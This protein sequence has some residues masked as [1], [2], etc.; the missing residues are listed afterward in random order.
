MEDQGGERL[1]TQFEFE[2]SIIFITNYD[3][4]GF[5]AKGNRLAPHFEAMISR[6]IYLDLAMKTRRDYMIRIEQIAP[7]MMVEAGMT[8]EDGKLIVDFI[9][10]NCDNLRELSLRMVMK[11]AN[12]MKMNRS[13]W[14]RLARVTCFKSK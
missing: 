7:A 4:D 14:E 2:G 1:P 11:L 9:N 5:I 10:K 6:S 12:L 3:F 8:V 13:D